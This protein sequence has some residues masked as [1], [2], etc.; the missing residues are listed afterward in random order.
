MTSHKSRFPT[1]HFTATYPPI[2]FSYFCYTQTLN[3]LNLMICVFYQIYFGMIQPLWEPSISKISEIKQIIRLL[4]LPL[5]GRSSFPLICSH[6]LLLSFQ[7][8]EAKPHPAFS[9]DLNHSY[10]YLY[11]LDSDLTSTVCAAVFCQ[12][13]SLR[14]YLP[15]WS[16]P[17]DLRASRELP[18]NYLPFQTSV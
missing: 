2:N 15:V 9:S 10:F 7:E 8:M 6:P 12:T 5:F 14:L 4:W 3:S 13:G 16:I 11:E 18:A 1:R 17:L